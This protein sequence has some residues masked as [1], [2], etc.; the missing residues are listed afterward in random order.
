MPFSSF[1]SMCTAPD[2]TLLGLYCTDCV[3]ADLLIVVCAL[4]ILCVASCC[5]EIMFR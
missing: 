5:L 3:L 4:P 2:F 1:N